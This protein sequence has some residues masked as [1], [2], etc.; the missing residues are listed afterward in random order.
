MAG[1]KAAKPCDQYHGWECEVSGG[2]CMFLFPDS[3]ACARR[4]GE[5]PDADKIPQDTEN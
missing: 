4:Y 1:C 3:E 5:G 2:E